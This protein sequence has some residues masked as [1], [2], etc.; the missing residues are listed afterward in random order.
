ML[1]PLTAW[2]RAEGGNY[3]DWLIPDQENFPLPQNQSMLVKG[4]L[5]TESIRW[6]EKFRSEGKRCYSLTHPYSH[7]YGRV[8]LLAEWGRLL[9]NDWHLHNTSILQLG[10]G[11]GAP[12]WKLNMP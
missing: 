9:C 5:E 8:P 6:Q 4:D 3:T 11:I 12:I 7:V 1:E 10:F 2:T